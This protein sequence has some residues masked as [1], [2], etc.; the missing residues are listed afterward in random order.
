MKRF[1]RTAP[2][3]HNYICTIFPILALTRCTRFFNP[4]SAKCGQGENSPKIPEFRLVKFRKQIAP[5]EVQAE[6]FH[7][8][9]HIIG[10]CPQTQKLE[11]P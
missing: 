10:F 8:N 7:L 5:F 11:A 3:T 6:R 9:G 2:T 1:G 4:F